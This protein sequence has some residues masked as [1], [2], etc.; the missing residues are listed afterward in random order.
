MR[1]YCPYEVSRCIHVGLLCVQ[2][3]AADRPTML[4]VVSMLSNETLQLSP[5]KQPAFFINTFGEEREISKNKPENCSIND[6]T[7]SMMEAR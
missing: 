3:Q 4:D 1:S 6:V 2:D 5:P 7:I